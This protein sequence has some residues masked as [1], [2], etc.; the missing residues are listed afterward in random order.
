MSLLALLA[1]DFG[2]FYGRVLF[3]PIVFFLLVGGAKY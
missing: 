1:R 2:T 3:I